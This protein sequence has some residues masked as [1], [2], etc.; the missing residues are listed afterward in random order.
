M[1]QS[2]RSPGTRASLQSG[3]AASSCL[4]VTPLCP[5][6][7]STTSA[8]ATSI[9]SSDA[10]LRSTAVA[11]TSTS[12][13]ATV[14]IAARRRHQPRSR[15]VAAATP[16]AAPSPA[17]AAAP[18]WRGPGEVGDEDKAV[19]CLLGAAV[20]NVLAAP[21]QGDRHFE[22]IRLRRNG[23]TDFWKYDI[24]AQPVQYGQYT[25]DFANLLAV[26]T[27]LSA[28]RG[29]EPAHLLG[30]LTRAYAEGG[31]S[32]EVEDASGGSSSGFLPARRYSPYDR[33]V[34]D[35][36]LAGTDPLKVPEL[37]ERY[38]AETTRRHASSSS[39]RP[40][41]EPHGPSD[42]GAA[43]R[44]A[45]IGL[46]YRRAGGERLLAAVRRSLE[47]S[48]PTPLGLDAAHVVAAAAA[49]CGRQQPGD[50][51]GATPAALLSHLLNDVAV[52][53]EQCGKLRLLRDNL[54]QLD[55]VTDWRAFYAGPQWARLTALFSRLSF[56][57]LATA[58]S[59]FASVV[60]L[61]LLS[62]WGRPEQAVIV[63]ASLGGHAPATAQTVGALA[64]TL[65]GQSWVPE[66]WWRGLG[67]GVEGEAGREAVV[68]AGR[69]LA[70]VELADG[71]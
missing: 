24:G 67:E 42:L 48:H 59:E 6:V 57:G 69:A 68:Q 9:S 8:P 2:V 51:V 62:S 31:S 7:A 27:S 33:L 14:P 44:A 20:G 43:A 12:S 30:A 53:A 35:A 36:V 34:M 60:L 5:L 71:L 26:A 54:F 40:D 55:E 46:A 63:A 41:R 49:W 11:S 58:G 64:G 23:V 39:D 37:A 38:L 70:A 47:F 65:Y 66:R 50:A 45:P 56:H 19:G 18:A 22:V 13:P 52:T 15:S 16:A 25:G 28:S 29:V 32:V 10:L 1:R 4:P 21:Y 17:A 61:A 3:R